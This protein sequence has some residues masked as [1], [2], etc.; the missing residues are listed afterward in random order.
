MGPDITFITQSPIVLEDDTQVYVSIAAERGGDRSFRAQGLRGDGNSAAARLA[1][2]VKTGQDQV[3]NFMIPRDRGRLNSSN[4]YAG[5]GMWGSA[6]AI[7]QKND[8][9]RDHRQQHHGLS[10]RDRL[11]VLATAT[12]VDLHPSAE[13]RE[14]CCRTRP[15]YRR[16]QVGET[17]VGIRRLR[18]GVRHGYAPP[19]HSP[20]DTTIPAR[21]RSRIPGQLP[22]SSELEP[23]QVR[24]GTSRRRRCCWVES[25]W[26]GPD[27]DWRCCWV[28]NGRRALWCGGHQMVPTGSPAACSRATA[29]DGERMLGGFSGTAVPADKA[30]REQAWAAGRRWIERPALCS[31]PPWIR[32]AAAPRER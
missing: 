6:G 24:T 14:L 26:W 15:R 25:I 32:W 17:R 22:L 10:K 21:L 29:S 8:R 7:D 30:G 28:F 19:Q 23:R 3:A 13:L 5:A 1:L 20:P 31:G 16:N 4:W 11:S 2:D 27:E 12:A 18:R 9:I